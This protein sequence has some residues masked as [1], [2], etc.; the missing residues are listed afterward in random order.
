MNGMDFLRDSVM[1]D[2]DFLR[3]YLRNL[4]HIAGLCEAFLSTCGLYFDKWYV[5]EFDPYGGY[6]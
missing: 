4:V 5:K 3:D 2:M 1:N 6:M